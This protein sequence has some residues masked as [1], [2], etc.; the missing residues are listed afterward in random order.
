M[1]FFAVTT[2]KGARWEP[3]R[4][5]REQDA[6]DQHAAFFDRLVEQGV[7][8]ERDLRT[9]FSTDPWAVN[10]VLRIKDVRS[11]SLWLDERQR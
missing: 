4:G 9:L 1:A 8:D 2:A 5:I 6:W 11:W 3:T 7:A 10:Q